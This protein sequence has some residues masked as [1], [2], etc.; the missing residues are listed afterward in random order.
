ML[1]QIVSSMTVI[2]ITCAEFSVVESRYPADATFLLPLFD[3]R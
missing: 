3:Q 2:A 1:I